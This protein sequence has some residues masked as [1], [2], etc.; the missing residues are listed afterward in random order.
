MRFVMGVMVIIPPIFITH[1]SMTRG[2]DKG[3]VGDLAV[4]QRI[5][6]YMMKLARNNQQIHLHMSLHNSHQY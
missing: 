4:K 2:M 5:L 1:S 6:M 3:P